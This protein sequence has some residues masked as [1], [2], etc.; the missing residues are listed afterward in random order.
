[1]F[2]YFAFLLQCVNFEQK[3]IFYVAVVS[4]CLC[5]R[6]FFS[7]FHFFIFCFFT[8]SLISSSASGSLPCRI[9]FFRLLMFRRSSKSVSF[10]A[11]SWNEEKNIIWIVSFPLR[12]NIHVLWSEL[13]LSDMTCELIL[14][15]PSL[16]VVGSIH[17]WN[18]LFYSVHMPFKGMVFKWRHFVYQ[19][20]RTFTWRVHWNRLHEVITCDLGMFRTTLKWRHMSVTF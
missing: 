2:L 11:M 17:T 6:F 20:L 18:F 9:N 12:Y 8:L 13:P 4:V 10:K 7:F 1:M 19:L 5:S 15:K 16:K 14:K 3:K